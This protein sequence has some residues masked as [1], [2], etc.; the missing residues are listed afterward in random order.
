LPYKQVFVNSPQRKLDHDQMYPFERFTED[1]KRALTLAQEEA[2]RSR[3]SYIGTE[4][5]LLGLVRVPSGTAHVALRELG[6]SI[7]PVRTMI[8]AAVAG[9]VRPAVKSVHPTSRVK[10]VIEMSFDEARRMGHPEVDTAHVLIGLV[11]EGDGIAAHVLQD[12]GFTAE[13]VVAAA[14]RALGVASSE[15]GRDRPRGM[16]SISIYSPGTRREI[17]HLIVLLTSPRISRLL[18]AKGLDVG[19]LTQQLLN[20]PEA[21]Q[22]LLDELNSR[23]VELTAAVA[24]QD[25]EQA[26]RLRDQVAE[27]MK[28]LEEAED[29]WLDSLGR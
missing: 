19:A 7:N 16:A 27:L 21:V 25:F 12:L 11:M 23:S 1:A 10:K 8:D 13:R 18:R 3:H 2:E 26:A 9:N 5:L 22:T 29:A 6:V 17:P 24:T 15:R 20:Q 14:E 4:H 28:K